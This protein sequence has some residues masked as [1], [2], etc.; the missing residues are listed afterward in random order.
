MDRRDFV[1]ALEGLPRRRDQVLPALHAAHALHGW[2]PEP[3]IEAVSD[4]TAVPLSELYGIISSY[5]ELRLAP[6]P[7]PQIEVCTGLSC[8]LAGAD[9]LLAAAERD[10]IDV[11]R[12]PCRFLC[13]VAPVA[14]VD[15][16][17]LGRLSAG[18]FMSALRRAEETVA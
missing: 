3:A 18:S 1:A 14:D 8:R 10:G 9:D 13:G 4:I 11:E 7:I 2:L 12:V 17:Y 5:S 15:G 16:R 6:P